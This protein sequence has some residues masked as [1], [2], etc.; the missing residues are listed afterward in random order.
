MKSFETNTANADYQEK[1]KAE[2]L[3]LE[4][5]K[6][7]QPKD[8]IAYFKEYG[9]GVPESIQLHFAE[10]KNLDRDIIE[11]LT[12]SRSSLVRSRLDKNQNLSS[13][14][15]G[16]LKEQTEERKNVLNKI[17]DDALSQQQ[18][19]YGKNMELEKQ[20]LL[21]KIQDKKDALLKEEGSV[22]EDLAEVATENTV[23]K[24]SGVFHTEDMDPPKEKKSKTGKAPA[25]TP[26][27]ASFPEDA[28]NMF[29][30]AG[31]SEDMMQ[32]WV[33]E[34]ADT[35]TQLLKNQQGARVEAKKYIGEESLEA[36]T[37]RNAEILAARDL[38]NFKNS[39][40][41][42]DSKV[43]P[44]KRKAYKNVEAQQIKEI[45]QD[46]KGLG[47]KTNQEIVEGMLKGSIDRTEVKSL[48]PKERV[49]ELKNYFSASHI[50]KDVYFGKDFDAAQD[51]E[52][53][54]NKNSL[55]EKIDE[56]ERKA[57]LENA[58]SD[59][60]SLFHEYG[61]KKQEGLPIDELES[62]KQNW[63]DAKQ[64]VMELDGSVPKEKAQDNAKESNISDNPVEEMTIISE[65]DDASAPQVSWGP[66]T[67]EVETTIDPEFSDHIKTGLESALEKMNENGPFGKAFNYL[68]GEN[69]KLRNNSRKWKGATDATSKAYKWWSKLGGDNKWAKLAKRI[70]VGGAIG[71]AAGSGGLIIAGGFAVSRVLMSAGAG[72]GAG[73][74]HEKLTK[75][76][77]E[78]KAKEIYEQDVDAKL[79]EGLNSFSLEG[80]ED[81]IYDSRDRELLE[82]LRDKKEQNIISEEERVLLGK[83]QEERHLR[84][85]HVNEF[86]KKIRN[87][88]DN[89]EK[90]LVEENKRNTLIVSAVAGLAA[91]MS[92][93][94]GPKILD[95]FENLDVNNSSSDYVPIPKE[96]P[97]NG[98]S[99]QGN[100]EIE[101]VVDPVQE[102][103]A[104]PNEMPS[105]AFTKEGD[106]ITQILKRQF[107]MD[108]NEE[109]AKK[110]G[111]EHGTPEEYATLAK[112]FGI[113]N[114]TQEVRLKLDVESA[115]VPKLDVD[116]N[117][118]IEQFKDGKLVDTYKVGDTFEGET[119]Q[120][121]ET[122]ENSADSSRDMRNA[123]EDQSQTVESAEVNLTES[124]ETD[125]LNNVES[126]ET[127]L[128]NLSAEE[129]YPNGNPSDRLSV[130]ETVVERTD[131]G[132]AESV[133]RT[134]TQIGSFQLIEVDGELTIEPLADFSFEGNVSNQSLDDFTELLDK[135]S[136]KNTVE[137]DGFGT[138]VPARLIELPDGAYA[139]EVSSLPNTLAD[140]N[141]QEL[142]EKMLNTF[143]MNEN[144]MYTS[145][146][147]E[148]GVER[149]YTRISRDQFDFINKTY[150][151]LNALSA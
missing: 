16:Y 55:N 2:A 131:N 1:K 21:E 13:E 40:T 124:T 107:D 123:G 41:E 139:L 94:F 111:I 44:L 54:K 81:L 20:A 128:T 84:A 61:R 27:S 129:L 96:V 126:V 7:A 109:L 76:K 99:L 17:N 82:N 36:N 9:E 65:G 118:I 140:A 11:N 48:L 52:M 149:N 25:N 127:N 92:L 43:I 70:V 148:D 112:E 145:T 71:A 51:I 138:K 108:G 106:G 100:E 134:T 59:A 62:A 103:V 24:I 39:Q 3:K 150:N 53:K 80:E 144:N 132:I 146:N 104:N 34:D 105:E 35:Y 50:S 12:F 38:L 91:G 117:T 19:D 136:F 102:K 22:E 47:A 66:G 113:M 85:I 116:G 89:L 72:A 30:A 58:Q 6:A 32:G 133:E 69:E 26:R 87:D 31:V 60:E 49:E 57:Q 45:S 137:M 79:S 37:A 101:K 130:S 125:A 115:Y 5:L 28:A 78:K 142:T 86:R 98:D 121:N 95:A 42:Q 10:K 120:A 14:Y 110:F 67:P 18:K 33:K 56:I 73:L 93:S 74:L 64:R 122:I 8:V 141:G 151:E 114:D 23:T 68:K 4:E 90:K 29:A 147:V 88:R 15:K 75:G 83:I 63:L 77:A 135:N 119:I 143:G 46:T 97:V